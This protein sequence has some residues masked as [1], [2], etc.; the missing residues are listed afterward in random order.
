MQNHNEIK[1]GQVESQLVVLFFSSLPESALKYREDM[2]LVLQDSF[3]SA[4]VMS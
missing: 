1:F 4:I 2:I 3:T